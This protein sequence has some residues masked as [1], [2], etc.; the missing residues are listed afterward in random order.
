MILHPFL[1]ALFPILFLFSKNAGSVSVRSLP[2]PIGLALSA[3]ALLWLLFSLLARDKRR[4]ALLTSLALLLFFSYGHALTLLLGRQLGPLKVS[5]QRDLLL[6]WAIA[7]LVGVWILLRVKNLGGI[8]RTFNAMA[9]FLVVITGISGCW[10]FF[11]FHRVAETP[12]SWEETLDLPLEELPDIY[13]IVLDGYGRAD[14]MRDYY[15][16]D[17]S[18]FIQWLTERGFYVAHR[19]RPNYTLTAPSIASALS[20]SYLDPLVKQVGPHSRN[21]IPLQ[22]R[23]RDGA[24]LSFLRLRGYSIIAFSSGFYPTE[25]RDAD[26]YLAP[27]VG[28]SPFQ[29]EL[30]NSTP[31]QVLPRLLDFFDLQRKLHAQRILFALD[32]LPATT[33]LPSPR[34]VFVHLVCP[35]PPYLFRADGTRWPATGRRFSLETRKDMP[36]EEYREKYTAQYAFVTRRIQSAIDQILRTSKKP[37]VI[38]LQSDHG[39]GFHPRMERGRYA[40]ERLAILNAYYFPDRNYTALH[41]GITP[42]NSFRVVLNQYL[43]TQLPLLEDRSYLNDPRGLYDFREVTLS[44]ERGDD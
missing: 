38:L 26:A 16:Y 28:F 40:R 23:I 4:S 27:P 33:R 14:T 32:R 9:V 12:D 44:E 25:L 31:L 35:H 7:F 2:V 22:R 30:I 39:P 8:T 13:Y 36:N 43:G 10:H 3:A 15:S 11:A 21:E 18:P 29:N 24:V 1:F 17:N 37:P 20:M 42:V 34:F 19:S 6:Y 41:E 5:G